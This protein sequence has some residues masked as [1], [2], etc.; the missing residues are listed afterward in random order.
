MLSFKKFFME[1]DDGFNYDNPG[2]SWLESKQ[3][4]AEKSRKGG[5]RI[6]GST[7]AWSDKPF[8]LPVS[9]LKNIRGA[10]GEEKWRND[11]KSSK[12]QSLEKEVGE[13]S[14]FSSDEHPI[15]LHIDHRGVPYVGEGNH[16]LAYAARH[17]ISHIHARVK[18]FNGG[19]QADGK[20]SPEKIKDMH[21]IDKADDE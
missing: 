10:S 21:K 19:E 16:R 3:R 5:T 7:T 1:D 9:K 8:R 12:Y 2:G 15:T 4:Q 20:F 13:P 14:N 11:P 18:Y 17:G 6:T